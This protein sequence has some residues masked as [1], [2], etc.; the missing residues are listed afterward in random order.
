MMAKAKQDILLYGLTETQLFH[1]LMIW[2]NGT[3]LHEFTPDFHRLQVEYWV[4]A[5]RA[6]L[7]GNVV[8]VGVYFPRNWI[9]PKYRTMGLPGSG[10]DVEADL[11]DMPFET[12]SLDG[13]IVTEVLEHCEQPFDAIKEVH[14]VLKPGGLLLTTSPFFW[15]WH[16]NEE[17]KDFWR[18]TADGWRLLLKD[19]SSVVIGACKWTDE[20]K[21]LYDLLRRFECWGHESRVTASTGYMCEATR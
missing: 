9:G 21:Q 6:R 18:F 7:Q 8:D 10:C 3:P 5:N 11:R 16:G 12:G 2:A 20:G 1:D 4:W 13:M 15:P 17:Y 19:F 14:R